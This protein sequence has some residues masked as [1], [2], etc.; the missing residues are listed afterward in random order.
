MTL[1]PRVVAPTVTI[2]QALQIMREH[3][4]RHLPVVDNGKLVGIVSER[5]LHLLEACARVN[6]ADTQVR[7]AMTQPVLTVYEHAPL[8]EVADQMVARRCGS[9]VI[10]ED[11]TIR[12]IFT[13]TDA[14]V[15][16]AELLRRAAA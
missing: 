15:A 14:L 16:L 5:D 11:G 1:G 8:D 6:P 10:T 3:T 12:G 13:A 4:L 7:E 2:A 9:V